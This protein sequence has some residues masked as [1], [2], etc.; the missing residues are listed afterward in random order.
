[1]SLIKQAEFF[2]KVDVSVLIARLVFSYL[3]ATYPCKSISQ[4]AETTSGGTPLRG[5]SEYYGGNIPWIKSGELNDGVI[6]QFEETITEEGLK[7]SSTKIYS[8][9]T[10]V[11]ALY[12]ATAGKTGIVGFDTASNQAVAAVY[13]NDEVERDYLFWFFRQKRFDYIQM[14]FGAAQPNISQAVVK[15]TK[16][17]VP[18]PNVQREVIDFLRDLENNRALTWTNALEPIWNKI[19]GLY[20]LYQARQTLLKELDQQQIYRQLLRQAILQEAVQGKLS[21]QDPTDEPA[22]E[23][24]KRMKA[25]KEKLVKAGKLKKEKELPPITEGEIPFELPEGWSWCRLGQLFRFIDYRGKTPIKSSS[26]IRIISAKNVRM[27]YIDNHPIEYMT[28]ELYK[29]WMVRG[30]PQNGD[31]LFV[32]EGGTMGNVAMIDLN[33]TYALAQRLINLQPFC[34][35]YN[36]FLFYGMLSSYFQNKVV[37]KSTGS[38]AKGI[39]SARLKQILIPLPPLAEQQRIVAK[40]QQLQQQLSE[41]EAQVQ[42]SKAYAGQLLQSV[43]RE[44]FGGRKV[45]EMKRE[46]VSMGVEG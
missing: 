9:G 30:F 14:S 5:H 17:A 29:K 27:G 4:I 24:L 44:A 42:Q 39:Q 25:E 32:T 18:K 28:S 31:I 7:S 38:A 22:T 40:V 33:F 36:L 45:C 13:P 43:L 8:K 21:K 19:N 12:G 15:A 34:Y 26:G 20:Q 10:L 2:D 46:R 6:T 16:I 23:L 37:E 1:M 35:D 3:E 41:L 11:L